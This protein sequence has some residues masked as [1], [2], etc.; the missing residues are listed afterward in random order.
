MARRG[1]GEGNLYQRKDGL[2]V[3]R[4]SVGYA[5]GKR[6]RKVVYGKTRR[7]AAERLTAVL[8]A[9]QQGL[10]VATERLTVAAYLL[11][12]VAGA[13]TSVRASTW[14]RYEELTRLHLAP[15]LGSIGLSRLSPADV[16]AALAG[17]LEAGSAPGTVRNARV[18]LGRALREAEAAGTIARNVARLTRPPRVTHEEMR[19]L[20]A[21]QVQA[22]LRVAGDDRLRA[23]FL[24]A[25]STGARQG[26]LLAT[27]WS[28]V[29]FVAGGVR[30][31]RTLGRDAE[32]RLAFGEPKT[33][34]SRRTIP[35]GPSTVEALRSHRRLQ[36]EE[37]LRAG[38]AWQDQGLVFTTEVGEPLDG[39]EVTRSF[40]QLLARAGLPRLRFH[41][42]RHSAAT[43]MLEAGT[44]PKVVAERLGH[45]TPTITLQV[46]SHV[47]ATMQRDAAA[48]LDR[49]IGG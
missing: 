42:A 22:L 23:L 4:V 38:S 29:D 48:L 13:R 49:A 10:P 18:V 45:S 14:R 8:R 30:V 16:G 44:N 27:R 35:L 6:R 31:V 17:M 3:G 28:D 1:N 20:D 11:R 33:A 32:G 9:R 25:F 46:Y 41:D 43:L 40:R 19:T 2:W 47:T 5:G 7:E 21:T 37:R 39:R 36:A 24:L 34:A 15:R 26:E 12:W